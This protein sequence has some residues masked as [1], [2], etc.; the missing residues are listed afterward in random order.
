MSTQEQTIHEHLGLLLDEGAALP[1]AFRAAGEHPEA[2]PLGKEFLEMALKLEGGASPADAIV[3]SKLPEPLRSHLA[4]GAANGRLSDTL[5]A[6]AKTGEIISSPHGDSEKLRLGI[7]IFL[8]IAFISWFFNYVVINMKSIYQELLEGETLPPLTGFLVNNSI[9]VAIGFTGLFVI[10]CIIRSVMRMDLPGRFKWKFWTYF[11]AKLYIGMESGLGVPEI[12][13]NLADQAPDKERRCLSS[14]LEMAGSGILFNEALRLNHAWSVVVED[15]LLHVDM[16]TSA[17]ALSALELFSS[18][19][20]TR[21]RTTCRIIL[22]CSLLSPILTA[23][24]IFMGVL[25]LFMP[26]VITDGPLGA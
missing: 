7:T 9:Y 13:R 16:S 21:K 4:T 3:A 10:I 15:M 2:G 17:G 14:A 22:L 24:Y 18:L 25:S 19:N 12:V 8:A 26:F 6:V 20:N 1:A 5:K 11:L 23:V